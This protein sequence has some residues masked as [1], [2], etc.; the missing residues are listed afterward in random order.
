MGNPMRLELPREGLLVYL[1][2]PYATRGSGIVVSEFEFQLSY[3]V[4]FRTNAFSKGMTPPYPTS[5]G[6]NSATT[7]LQEE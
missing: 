6:L 2:N 3:Y 5:Y 1:A 4:N 7:V